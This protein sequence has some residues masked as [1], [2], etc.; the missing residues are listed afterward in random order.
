MVVGITTTCTCTCIQCLYIAITN[1]AASSN[2]AHGE[3]YPIQQYVIKG[4]QWLATGRWVSPNTLI[5]ST[6]KIDRL[7]IT[8]IL[9]KVVLNII[10]LTH[11]IYNMTIIFN[12]QISINT[13]K[14][15]LN[16][17]F[18][19]FWFNY[20]SLFN[21]FCPEY[22]WSFVG[23]VLHWWKQ[24]LDSL[25]ELVVD[26]WL[27]LNLKLSKFRFDATL[28]WRRLVKL[29]WLNIVIIN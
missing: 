1:K 11:Y 7:D 19:V 8:E 9:L 3:M 21:L 29:L 10:T 5:S 28:L 18:F 2:P 17:H 26:S 6:N 13:F 4:C 12:I 22:P 25:L 24:V 20:V 16:Y 23:Y 15:F 14:N 27:N